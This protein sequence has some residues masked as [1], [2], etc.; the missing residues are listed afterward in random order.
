MKIRNL[1]FLSFPAAICF[2]LSSCNPTKKLTEGEYLLDKNAVIDKYGSL[3]KTEMETYIKQK[4]NRKLLFWRMYL[5]IYNSIDQG[6]LDR[7]KAKRIAKREAYN[8]R[9]T[10]KF[11]RINAKREAK[12]KKKLEYSLKDKKPF[13]FRE[14]WLSVGEPPVIY[15]SL[16]AKKSAKQIKLYANNKGYFN[17]VVKDSV[18]QPVHKKVK[19]YYIIHEGKPYTVR[20]LS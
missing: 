7:I 2:A 4:P 14:W 18:S 8:A 9:K 5:H 20:N 6:K 15:D 17:S 12:G 3:D 13:I 1:I 16:L 19:S 10:E 11:N